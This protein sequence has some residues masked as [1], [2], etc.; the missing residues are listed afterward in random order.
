MAVHY[1]PNSW[2]ADQN[3]LTDATPSLGTSALKWLRIWARR[4]FT[5]GTAHVAGDWAPTGWGSGASVSAV[6]GDDSH[7]TVTVTS[8]TSPSANPTVVL[9]FKD[10]TWT[11]APFAFAELVSP[12]DSLMTP[13]R[14]SATTATTMTL[15]FYGTP[16]ASTAYQMRFFVFGGA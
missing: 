13:V 10:G 6:S 15:T 7:G 12:T 9:T 3:P 8:G 4:L 14:V 5:S 1:E 16:A 2:N 11:N